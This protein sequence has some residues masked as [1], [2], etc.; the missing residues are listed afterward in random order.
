MY[1]KKCALFLAILTCFQSFSSVYSAEEQTVSNIRQGEISD[2]EARFELAK[3]L[4][5]QK[6]FSEALQELS[7]ITQQKPDF[8]EAKIEMDKALY[9]NGDK[10][11][12]LADLAKLSESISKPSLKIALADVYIDIQKFNQA[13]PL[14]QSYLIEHPD[15][16]KTLLKYAEVLSWNK[17]YADS[18]QAYRALLAK[19][20]ADIQVRRKYALVLIWMGNPEEGAE[21][22]KK[23][24]SE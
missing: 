9:L 20:P 17:Q 22:L 2:W 8:V 19:R 11:Q 16:L 13:T 21:E 18:I 15:D 1:L 14:L 12:A 6:K 24:L 4:I 23:T 10:E 3:V 5:Y 7:K